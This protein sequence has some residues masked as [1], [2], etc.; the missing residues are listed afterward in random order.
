MGACSRRGSDLASFSRAANRTFTGDH[1]LCDGDRLLPSVY[2]LGAPKAA[3]TSLAFDLG[4]GAG[5]HCAGGQ[6]EWVF[7]TPG[8][9]R[10]FGVGSQPARDAIRQQWLAGL[11]TCPVDGERQVAG[12]FSPQNLRQVARPIRRRVATL[13]LREQ[14][15]A[16]SPRTD[17]L[18]NVLQTLYG[19]KASEVTFVVMV[20]EPL[21]RIVSH[22]YY[23]VKLRSQN[24]MSGVDAMLSGKGS[25]EQVWFGM[26]GHQM[27]VWLDVFPARQF[28]V[29]PYLA[30]GKG[31]TSSIAQDLSERM[32]Y[33]M[34]DARGAAA[35]QNGGTAS[36]PPLEDVTT[37]EFRQMF[38]AF[39]AEDKSKL[40][41]LL[42]QGHTEGMGLADYDGAVG[43]EGDVKRWLEAWW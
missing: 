28:Y 43:N 25:D 20:R 40:I 11:P 27:S 34:V 30:Y 9:L 35:D 39:M 38:N 31:N 7:W 6:K 16:E 21:S 14:G 12:D 8:K 29:I 17:G 5:V 2:I 36:H 37:P 22:W 10:A 1:N 3:T 33:E 18:P 4:A 19:P 41:S 42:A 13:L 26:Y 32:H 15:G 24:F 23:F